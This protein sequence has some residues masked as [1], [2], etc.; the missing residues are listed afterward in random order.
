MRE[1]GSIGYG[2]L[3]RWLFLDFSRAPRSTAS[4]RLK[5]KLSGINLGVA[6]SP[7]TTPLASIRE[8]RVGLSL[9]PP[10]E[11]GSSLAAVFT[12]VS[13]AMGAGCLSLPFMFRQCGVVLGT[14]LLLLGALLAHISLLVLMVCARYT[15]SLSMSRLVS[16]AQAGGGRVVDVVI[17]VYGI[18]AVLCY[19][20][21]VGDFFSGIVQ[22]PFLGWNV[23]REALIVGIAAFVVWPLSLLRSLTALRYICVLSVLAVCVTAVV[24]ALKAPAEALATLEGAEASGEDMELKWWAGDG[25]TW[26]Q[27]FSIAVFAFAA[28]TNAVPVATSLRHADARTIW[29]VS[30]CSV[31]IEFV[32]YAV[33]GLGGYYSF[34]GL[35]KQDF[36]LN[37]RNDD[38]VMFGVRCVYGV[39]VCLG[40]PINLSPAA[41]SILDLVSPG[42]RRRGL[43]P[44]VVTIVVAAC[45]WVAIRNERVADVI[46][47][48]GASF[49]ALIGLAWPARIY[50]K[51]LFDLHP[52][53]LATTLYCLLAGAALTGFAAF[54]V[55]AVGGRR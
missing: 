14:L 24:V 3:W 35:T 20:I 41:A 1:Y 55:Q 43:H 2:E 9:L 51:V 19:F 23:S 5:R 36:I 6:Q 30:L 18:A 26:L 49:G 7:A 33:M 28:H 16:L 11:E 25:S 38:I 29:S 37:Y 45:A 17:A 44:L 34:R 27:S 54:G 52:P 8:E 32:F 31:C 10:V 21:F 40:A 12:L 46:G 13:S 50:S 42:R 53:R 15:D 47:L 48:L 4:R 22:S 39:V